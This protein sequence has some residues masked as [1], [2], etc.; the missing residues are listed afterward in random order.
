[1]AS[2]AVALACLLA[3]CDRPAAA[4][5]PAAPVHAA[6]RDHL[7]RPAYFRE[8]L[9]ELAARPELQGHPLR[10]HR[11]AYFY[12]D[13][14][15]LLWL[16]SPD[17]PAALLRYT[18]ADGYPA[19]GMRWEVVAAGHEAS[20]TVLEPDLLDLDALPLEGLPVAAAAADAQLRRMRAEAGADAASQDALAT[21][22]DSL[23]YVIG[24]ADGGPGWR[25]DINPIPMRCERTWRF[26]FA[27]DGA[28]REVEAMPDLA[29][30]ADCDA[31]R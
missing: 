13:G 1:M 6:E 26:H 30:P 11:F 15:V 4:P 14:T 17:D 23:Y 22:P 10:L 7:H 20:P 31:A 19:S 21:G 12:A 28:L 29:R 18:Y 2:A 8:R 24:Q 25:A 27:P 9:A 3:A 16:Q 5:P